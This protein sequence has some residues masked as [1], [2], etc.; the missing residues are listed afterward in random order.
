MECCEG[1]NNPPDDERCMMNVVYVSVDVAD[2]MEFSSQSK[3]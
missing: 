3:P 2:E 1:L